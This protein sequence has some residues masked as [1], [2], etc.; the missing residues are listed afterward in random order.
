[1]PE[2]DARKHRA[3]EIPACKAIIM[4]V[5]IGHLPARGRVA[6]SARHPAEDFDVI[7]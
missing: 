3:A 2:A 4:M 5:A 6:K 1:M 7:R